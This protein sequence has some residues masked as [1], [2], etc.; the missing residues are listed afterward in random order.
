MGLELERPAHCILQI[1]R[2]DGVGSRKFKFFS[3]FFIFNFLV[4]SFQNCEQQS[5]IT[6]SSSH[7]PDESHR[8]SSSANSTLRQFNF[9]SASTVDKNI[10]RYGIN[11]WV[12]RPTPP[13]QVVMD[14]FYP[15]FG[16]VSDGSFYQRPLD[17]SYSSHINQF[18]PQLSA[19]QMTASGGDPNKMAAFRAAIQMDLPQPNER[20]KLYP[21][22]SVVADPLILVQ[23]FQKPYMVR[24]GDYQ[25]WVNIHGSGRNLVSEKSFQTNNYVGN[26]SCP[27]GID[28]NKLK[29]TLGY[30]IK[31]N[32]LA[33]Q[34]DSVEMLI[35]NSLNPWRWAGPINATH[36][37]EQPSMAMVIDV[38][39]DKALAAG[40]NL[41]KFAHGLSNKRILLEYA[42]DLSFTDLRSTL[43]EY[44]ID[45]FLNGSSGFDLISKIKSIT[46]GNLMPFPY[47]NR[48]YYNKR[49]YKPSFQLSLM[50][51]LREDQ[52]GWMSQEFMLASMDYDRDGQSYPL[53]PNP[54]M[55]NF[56]YEGGSVPDSGVSWYR[57]K[58]NALTDV[59]GIIPEGRNQILKSGNSFWAIPPFQNSSNVLWGTIDLTEFVKV[60][61]GH[62]FLPGHLPLPSNPNQKIWDKLNLNWAGVVFESH[63]PFKSKVTVK[64][65]NILYQ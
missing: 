65:F 58:V 44:N 12:Q 25:G 13:I 64:H 59:P 10:L 39:K 41:T 63:G 34:S 32:D 50:V 18:L 16:D 21:G 52:I 54:A 62:Q 35:D 31:R 53:S 60:A 1:V 3:I 29:Q 43:R 27:L 20:F 26:L 23:T 33:T 42:I 8:G 46:F 49:L 40:D 9:Q 14:R 7:K 36:H 37:V 48:Q 5:F 38:S 45:N 51:N 30:S 28:P 56:I 15:N 47:E 4:I 6:E 17:G 2:G 55:N 57:L 22:C 24:Q 11:N 61:K 19:L